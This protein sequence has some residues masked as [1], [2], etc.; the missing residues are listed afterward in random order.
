[1][2]QSIKDASAKGGIPKHLVN[3]SHAK[4]RSVA[5]NTL[6]V[7]EETTILLCWV[8]AKIGTKLGWIIYSEDWVPSSLCSDYVIQAHPEC[9]C[10]TTRDVIYYSPWLKT[11]IWK[12]F[13]WFPSWNSAGQRSLQRSKGLQKSNDGMQSDN[14]CQR[15]GVA[16]TLRYYYLLC[17]EEISSLTSGV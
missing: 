10:P 13:H 7:W 6:V 12:I 15:R 14:S 16:R 4:L 9:S 8:T 2:V 3:V 17:S 11:T 5:T 1:M